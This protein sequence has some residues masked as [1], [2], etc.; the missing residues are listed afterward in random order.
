MYIY[1]YVICSSDRWVTKLLVN[2]EDRYFSNSNEQTLVPN[3]VRGLIVLPCLR[4][5][6]TVSDAIYWSCALVQ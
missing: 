3:R 5:I 1:V 4:S 6:R 2:G